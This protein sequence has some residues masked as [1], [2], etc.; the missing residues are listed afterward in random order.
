MS[1]SCIDGIHAHGLFTNLVEAW[2]A[3]RPTMTALGRKGSWLCLSSAL[4]R[5]PFM[6]L[7]A[8]SSA[9]WLSVVRMCT[10]FRRWESSF[11]SRPP[12]PP[13]FSLN[14]VVENKQCRTHAW[15]W[16]WRRRCLLQFL[17]SCARTQRFQSKP[18]TGHCTHESGLTV[19]LCARL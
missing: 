9:G 7:D 6:M 18:L 11:L 1:R 16:R 4:K 19:S 5:L 10:I 8:R 12:V 3:S 15:L 14:E 17:L 2:A 13:V